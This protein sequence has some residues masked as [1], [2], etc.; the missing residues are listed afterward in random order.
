MKKLIIL[1]GIAMLTFTSCGVNSSNNIDIDGE[2]MTYFKDS[3]TGLC[4]GAI[5]SRKTMSASTTGLGLTCVP[6][7]KVKHLIK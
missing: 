4:F 2:D 6:C 3:R 5:A 7:D 1:L